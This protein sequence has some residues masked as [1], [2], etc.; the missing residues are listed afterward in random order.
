MAKDLRSVIS[1]LER[2]EK[3]HT[4]KAEECRNALQALRKVMGAGEPADPAPKPAFRRLASPSKP[5]KVAKRL[6]MPKSAS[7]TTP[8]TPVDYAAREERVLATVRKFDGEPVS[9]QKIGVLIDQKEFTPAV[10][11]DLL[12]RLW[13]AGRLMRHGT[14]G[15]TTYSIPMPIVGESTHS[16][17]VNGSG[18]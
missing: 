12:H 16:G 17:Y 6:A 3:F 5:A 4:G 9:R 2:D 14:L 13:K 1:E 11:T 8:R 18:R 15:K 7:A 10:I